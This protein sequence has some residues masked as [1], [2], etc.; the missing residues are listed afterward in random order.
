M[1]LNDSGFF[2]DSEGCEDD[3]L[4][5]LREIF[6]VAEDDIVIEMARIYFNEIVSGI[7]MGELSDEHS[8]REDARRRIIQRRLNLL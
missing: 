6:S 8:V 7:P 2:S 5:H 1:P 3:E 4:E